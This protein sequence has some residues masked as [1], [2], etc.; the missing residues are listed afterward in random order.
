MKQIIYGATEQLKDGSHIIIEC[1]FS[2][3]K[4]DLKS[5]KQPATGC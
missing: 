2:E 3:F 5:F 4:Q 1:E